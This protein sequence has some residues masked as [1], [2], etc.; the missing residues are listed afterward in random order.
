MPGGG[1]KLGIT[2][3]NPAP[4]RLLDLT[5]SLRR[6]DLRAT[7]VDRVELAYLRFLLADP[8]PLF[9]LVRTPLGYLLLDREG[10]TE[11][12]PYLEGRQAWSRL[13]LLALVGRRRSG[14]QRRAEAGLR[15]LAVARVRRGALAQVLLA[16]LPQGF[17]Y[18][19]TGHSNLTERV[20]RAV[21]RAGGEIHVLVHDVIPLAL[22]QFQRPETV[23]PFADKMRRVSRFADRVIYNSHD[24]QRQAEAELSGMGR[25]PPCIVAHLGTIQPRP[26]PATLPSGLPPKAP[27]FICVGTLEPRKNHAFLLDLW[28][29]WGP[30]APPLLLCGRRGWNN[31]ALFDRLDA[32]PEGHPVREVPGLNDAALAALVKGARGALFPS[33]AEGFGLPPLEAAQ[34]GTRVLCNDLAVLREFLGDNAV[35]ADV[36]ADYLWLNTLKDWAQDPPAAATL[37]PFEGPTWEAHFKAVLRSG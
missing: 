1:T 8:V 31:A 29:A 23:A 10:M 2:T 22:P 24:T 4:A 30:E 14:A 11:A 17:V 25:V 33:L 20:F 18:Y 28:E 3:D 5:R 37:P 35:Y 15:R 19:N 6:A 32:L 16:H 9:G 26:N 12:L 27:Y 7:G 34:L 36:S 21:Q 13:D